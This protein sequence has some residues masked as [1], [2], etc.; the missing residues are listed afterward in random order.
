MSSRLAVDAYGRTV[1]VVTTP[2]PDL[3][4]GYRFVVVD[5]RLV[6]LLP[7]PDRLPSPRERM[8]VRAPYDSNSAKR[9]RAQLI[10]VPDDQLDEASALK[11]AYAEQR[12]EPADLIGRAA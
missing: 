5:G 8:D 12:R 6:G 1:A 11:A 7:T 4:P 10:E 2:L 9:R 3:D